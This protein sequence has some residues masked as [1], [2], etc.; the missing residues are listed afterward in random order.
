L[1]AFSIASSDLIKKIDGYVSA[2][3]LEE[4]VGSRALSKDKSNFVNNLI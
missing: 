3:L 4:G 1:T 2:Q